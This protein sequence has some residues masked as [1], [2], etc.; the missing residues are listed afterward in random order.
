MFRRTPKYSVTTAALVLIAVAAFGLRFASRYLPEK[1]PNRMNEEYGEYA[2]R[3]MRETV[4]WYSF[5]SEVFQHAKARG[6]LI[7]LDIGTVASLNAK[8]FSEDYATDGEYRQLLHDHFEA[9]KVDALELPWVVDAFELEAQSFFGSER[10][11]AIALDESGGVLDWSP[12]VSKEGDGSLSGWLEELARLRYSDMVEVRRRGADSLK[13]RANLATRALAPGQ[14]SPD[15]VLRWRGQWRAAATAGEFERST[16]PVTAVPMQLLLAV[17][18][19]ASR[20]AAL[21]LLL[22]LAGSPCYDAIDG[23]FFL[24]AKGEGWTSPVASKRTGHSLQLAA[25]FAEAGAK[26]NI[27]LF[28]AV[29]RI[30]AAWSATRQ[31]N[32]VFDSGLSTDQDDSGW[33]PY[34]S[35]SG[36]EVEEFQFRV[37][38]LGL[39][40]ILGAEGFA[41]SVD[42][43]RT[44]RVLSDAAQLRKLRASKRAPRTDS[45]Q[46]ANQNGQAISGLF[47]IAAALNDS[48]VSR[49]AKGSYDAA[50]ATF[51]LP[52]GD[53]H[54][55]AGGIDGRKTGYLES[56]VWM[57]RAAL[58]GYLATDDP[59]MLRDAKLISDRMLEL[60]LGESGALM[61]YLPSLM[62][63]VNYDLPVFRVEDT[64]LP[65]ANALAVMN[66]ADLAAL[67]GLPGY[68]KNAVQIVAAFSGKFA[69]SAPP[70]GLVLAAQRIY[71]PVR[72]PSKR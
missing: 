18:D 64:D 9:V 65:S 51:M 37:G 66:L 22:D 36:G 27:P 41:N 39:P 1:R 40:Q 15:L 48:A 35:F 6:K 54:H 32:G 57:A 26:Y 46:Y 69:Q 59:A 2:R 33:S 61:Q 67:T 31:V 14:C 60:F 42:E 50:R 10:F 55:A 3:S 68:R 38:P 21:N 5:G 70:A 29:A 12:L 71:D 45:G 44:Q 56:Y 47:K 34:Y 49:R 24:T 4:D 72:P 11:L 52:L 58:D 19:E 23:G 62:S 13:R 63:M 7:F 16:V 20:V 43:Q 28:Q 25:T 53:V 30:T 17:E 8:R